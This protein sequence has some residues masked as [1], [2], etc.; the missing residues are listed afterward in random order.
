MAKIP[1]YR[2]RAG[3]DPA[4]VTLRDARTKKRRDYWLG[5]ANS[6]ESRE[7]YHIVIAAWEASGR[8]FPDPTN[9]QAQSMQSRDDASR[10]SPRVRT[11]RGPCR[12]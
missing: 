12:P 1:S 7:K 5:P 11:G 10:H 4:L 6:P 3:Y 9:P 2:I 8:C